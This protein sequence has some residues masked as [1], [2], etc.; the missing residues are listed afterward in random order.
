MRVMWTLPTRTYGR[1]I[2]D[3]RQNRVA[4][5]S[6]LAL[7]GILGI[8]AAVGLSSCGG[9]SEAIGTGTITRSLPAVTAA[10]GPVTVT[11]TLPAATETVAVTETKPGVAQTRPVVTETV[12]LTETAPAVTETELT[13][14][15]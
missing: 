1:Q 4:A 15:R 10:A 11:E 3:F 6:G 8:L 12:T 2:V 5:G 14:R 13:R 9:N 7:A